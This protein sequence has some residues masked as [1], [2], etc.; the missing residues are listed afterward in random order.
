MFGPILSITG[1]HPTPLRDLSFSDC[2]DARTPVLNNQVISIFK[3]KT[4]LLL[5]PPFFASIQSTAV[6]VQRVG[7]VHPLNTSVYRPEVT[8]KEQK[9]RTQCK[10]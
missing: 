7:D 4:K 10:G 1:R 9:E 5:R 3:Q 2:L 8:F 6:S